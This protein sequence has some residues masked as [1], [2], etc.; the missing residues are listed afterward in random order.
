MRIVGQ[1]YNSKETITHVNGNCFLTVMGRPMDEEKL[2][3]VRK[4]MAKRTSIM[5]QTI[6]QER[7]VEF[8]NGHS[9][10]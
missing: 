2:Y 3:Q 5:F 10:K 9:S 4:D 7:A 1:K 6:Y 8:L